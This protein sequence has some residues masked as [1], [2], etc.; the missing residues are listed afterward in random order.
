MSNSVL[1]RE[2][3]ARQAMGIG[4]VALAWLLKQE[5]CV[6]KPPTVD[7]RPHNDLKPR[8][9]PTPPRAT[10]MISL[11]Q[12]GGPSHVDLCD[13]KP[14]LSRFSGTDYAED[15]QF[16]FVNDASKKLYGSPFRFQQHGACGTELSELLP[17]TA[18]VVDDL[19]LI[20]S[21]HTGAN[22]HE[23]SIRYFHG[24]IPAVLGRPTLGS[25][26]VYGLGCESQDLP[27]YMVLS[28]PGGLPVDGVTNWSN[29][30]MPAIFQG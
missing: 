1:R 28:D 24:G 20:R 5:S 15:I 14:E 22:G 21:M 9:P 23:V 12:H 13:P 18:S 19:C 26:L 3:L 16:S 7:A 8:M 11:F 6:A 25:W 30:F 27:A 4:S 10:A 29:G 17:H 2:F